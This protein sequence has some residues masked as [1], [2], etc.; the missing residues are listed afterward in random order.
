VCV[1]TLAFPSEWSSDRQTN[2]RASALGWGVTPQPPSWGRKSH[3]FGAAPGCSNSTLPRCTVAFQGVGSWLTR[4]GGNAW[5]ST[6]NGE[7]QGGSGKAGKLQVSAAG[8]FGKDAAARFE[9][10]VRAVLALP[11]LKFRGL[12]V[13]GSGHL[14]LQAEGLCVTAPG[15]PRLPQRSWKLPGL[16]RSLRSCQCGQLARVTTLQQKAVARR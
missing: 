6:R 8:A 5:R 9:T 16:P 10:T 7:E 3:C 14:V 11:S 4:C 15:K 12:D 2:E 13:S 1:S